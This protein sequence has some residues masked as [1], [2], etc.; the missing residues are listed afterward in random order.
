MGFVMKLLIK[1]IYRICV[2]LH[3][4][5]RTRGEVRRQ[6]TGVAS[7][8]LPHESWGLNSAGLAWQQ[9]PLPP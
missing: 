3:M 1:N 9:A 4:Y 2:C 8:L 7:F 5:H 6:L